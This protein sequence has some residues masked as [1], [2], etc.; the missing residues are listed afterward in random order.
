MRIQFNWLMG[1]R[2]P[3]PQKDLKLCFQYHID[4]MSETDLTL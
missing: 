4:N 3:V 2:N 1:H